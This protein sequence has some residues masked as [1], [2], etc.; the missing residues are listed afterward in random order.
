MIQL[1]V[2]LPTE[3]LLDETVLKVTAEASDG[4]FTLLPR[5]IDFATTLVPGLFS[6]EREDGQEVF[7]AMAEGVLVKRG[8]RVNVSARN[9]VAGE[10]LDTLWQTVRE[11]YARLD[12]QERK[13]RSVIASLETALARQLAAL[14]DESP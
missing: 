11:Q 9:A 14:G 6:Y 5:H 13:A 3:V 8:F 2:L 7:L 4:S 1:K 10:D 12:D